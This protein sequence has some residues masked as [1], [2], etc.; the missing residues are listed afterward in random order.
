MVEAYSEE[1]G[2]IDFGREFKIDEIGAEQFEFEASALIDTPEIGGLL[3]KIL[4]MIAFPN[5][6]TLIDSESSH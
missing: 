3:P 5:L 4:G 1:P 6:A 2:G